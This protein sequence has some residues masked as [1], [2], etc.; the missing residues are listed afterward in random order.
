VFSQP[1]WLAGL[2]VTTVLVVGY[3]WAQRRRRRDTMLFTNLALLE[4][5]A[6]H[7]TGWYRH[8]PAVVLIAALTVMIGGLAGPQA[9]AKV[10]RNR[11]TVMLVI[12]V[13][14]SMQ[15]TDV[16]PT[17]LAAAQAAAVAFTDQLPAG[18]NLGLESFA[19]TAAVLVAPTTDREPVKRAITELKLAESTATGEAIFAAVA[20]VQAFSQTWAGSGDGGPPAPAQIVL[21][22]DGGQTVPDGPDAENQPRGAFTAARAAAAAH[23]PVSTISFGTDYG[24]IQLDPDR[25]PV[26]VPVD[27]D[28][29]RQVAQLSGGEFFAATSG[30]QLQQVY[31]RLGDDIGY[32]LRPVDISRV[33]LAAAT[34]LMIAGLSSGI[35]LGRRLP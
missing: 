30:I 10:P 25:P 11:T 15:A 19:G 18:I 2:L 24:T 8:V 21:E 4:R 3:V 9:L 1:W 29:L 35:L 32:E 7:R 13:S 16:A 6:P 14:L 33:W 26:P 17:R 12:D 28:A 23:I 34:V 22:S 5:I 31:G 20:A 27:N